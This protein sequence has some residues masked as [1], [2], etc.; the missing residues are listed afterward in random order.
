MSSP[1]QHGQSSGLRRS[2]RQFRQE[3]VDPEFEISA[4]PSQREEY[5]EERDLDRVDDDDERI[6]LER[7]RE[8]ERELIKEEL[9]GLK[10]RMGEL[11]GRLSANANKNES[12]PS[13]LLHSRSANTRRKQKQKQSTERDERVQ[14]PTRRNSS[15]SSSSTKSTIHESEV[16]KEL[17]RLIPCYNGH[18][19]IQKLMEYIDSFEA[20]AASM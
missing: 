19:G 14:S 3:S 7:E 15:K 1:K 18:G 6:R 16:I 5:D 17:I 4:V 11:E 13:A 20:Y 12:I 2:T 10:E 8:E 9:V